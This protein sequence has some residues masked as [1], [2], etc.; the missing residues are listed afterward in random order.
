MSVAAAILAAGASRRLGQAKQL[1][2]L[3]A[4]TLLER[5]VRVAVEA[6]CE[7][8]LLVLGARA[9]EILAACELDG[10][11][12]VINADW[13]S[14][15][16]S[17]IHAALASL[18]AGV[19]GLVLMTCDQPAIT[20]EHLRR[21]MDAAGVHATGSRYAGRIGVPAYFPADA[22]QALAGLKGDEG[23][24]SLLSQGPAL[25]LPGGELDVDTAAD[26]AQ[27]QLRFG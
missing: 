9:E 10:A 15:M 22:F 6:G 8:V 20:A 12:V 2:R 5:A 27:A 11:R 23:A 26:L 3:G 7:P 21:L 17:S 24:R 18:P 4:E 13:E 19:G 25:D 16:A 1:A 14:G